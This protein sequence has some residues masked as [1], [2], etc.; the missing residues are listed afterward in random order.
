MRTKLSGDPEITAMNSVSEALVDLDD[1]ARG[2]V[3]SWATQRFGITEMGQPDPTG[4]DGN[5]PKGESFKGQEFDAFVDLFDKSNATTGPEKA[6]V[7]A[8][9]FQVAQGADSFKGQEVNNALKDL[10]QGVAN[11]TESLAGLQERKPSLVRQMAK[12]GKSKQSR[13]TYKL[14]EAGI[15]EVERMISG[16]AEENGS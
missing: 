3:L 1:D 8:Y 10:G 11:I 4:Q 5:S 9:W 16:T 12:S 15:R 13:K 14:T 7:G 2:R 6:L